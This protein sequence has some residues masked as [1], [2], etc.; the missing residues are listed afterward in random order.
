MLLL[1]LHIIHSPSFP[2]SKLIATD[3]LGDAVATAP[4]FLIFNLALLPYNVNSCSGFV[5][6]IPTL[7]ELVIRNLSSVEL[8]TNL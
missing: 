3:L 6:P 5:V 7:P 2:F 1:E 8:V 4:L